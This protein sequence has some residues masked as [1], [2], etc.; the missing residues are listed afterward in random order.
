MPPVKMTSSAQMSRTSDGSASHSSASP[1]ATPA[2]I[3]SSR[4]RWRWSDI[5]GSLRRKSGW[6][7]RLFRPAIMRPVGASRQG[8]VS[9]TVGPCRRPTAP[10]HRPA[11][12]SSSWALPHSSPAVVAEPASA[13]SVRR[14][15][16]AH[17]GAQR[18]QRDRHPPRLHGR[19]RLARAQAGRPPAVDDVSDRRLPGSLRLPA[20]HHPAPGS[21]D[22]RDRRGLQD[23]RRVAPDHEL[24][25]GLRADR[26]H[27]D[28]DRDRVRSPGARR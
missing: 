22:R 13:F 5:G 1:P 20:R 7:G 19:R 8:R 23:L 17:L 28:Q 11:A 15:W 25:L 27:R 18:R 16:T 12:S 21:R 9:C 2:S 3:R 26:R 10:P 4:D 14:T 24:G 6:S